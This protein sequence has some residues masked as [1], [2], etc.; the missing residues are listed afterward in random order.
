MTVSGSGRGSVGGVGTLFT[1]SAVQCS[2]YFYV[3]E[4][5]KADF[6][7]GTIHVSQ[8][9]SLQPAVWSVFPCEIQRC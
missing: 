2:F 4:S 5:T 9:V 8:G 6:F 3:S 1:I 7:D